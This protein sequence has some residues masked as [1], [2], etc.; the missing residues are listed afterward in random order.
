MDLPF[1]FR[2][3]AGTSWTTGTPQIHMSSKFNL[4]NHKKR[5]NNPYS[6]QFENSSGD[7]V[8]FR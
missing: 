8:L 7:V 2:A 5:F 6:S 3:E 1:T 4:L